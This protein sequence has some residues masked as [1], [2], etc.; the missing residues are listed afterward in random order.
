[1]TFD[2]SGFDKLLIQIINSMLHLLPRE[3]LKCTVQ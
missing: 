1:L 2:C 3:A